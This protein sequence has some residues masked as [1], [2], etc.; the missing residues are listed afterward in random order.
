MAAVMESF[1]LAW[2][3]L[4]PGSCGMW[5]VG[6]SSSVPCCGGSMAVGGDMVEMQERK[7]WL[8]SER[9]RERE[10]LG[11]DVLSLC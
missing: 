8:E 2:C 6:C 11:E 10:L 4:I 1:L 3:L 9:E 7:R 5:F